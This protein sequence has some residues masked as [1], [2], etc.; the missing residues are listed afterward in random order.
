[1]DADALGRA[2][3]WLLR[4]THLMDPA[5]FAG[6]VDEAARQLGAGGAC[7]YL[8]SRDQQQLLPFPPG[9]GTAQSLDGTLAGRAYRT[10]ETV[11]PGDS[12]RAWVPLLD[13]TERLGVLELTA[14]PDSPVDNLVEEAVPFAALVAE[15]VVSKGQYSDAFERARR[16]VPMGIAAEMLWRQLPPLTYATPDVVVSA[17]LEPWNEVGG[18]AFD[19]SLDGDVLRLAVFDGMGHG[20]S[21]TLMAGVALAGYR[22]ARRSG[23]SLLETVAT[24][25]D[26]LG[27]Q[28]GPE[29]F[30]TALLAELQLKTGL[31]RMVSAA[32]PAPVLVRNGKAVGELGLTPGVPLG[33]GDRSDTVTELS[34]QPTDRLLLMTD[35]V[36]EA[37]SSDG[38]FFGIDRLLDLLVRQESLRQPPPET[39]RRLIAAVLEHQSGM[40]QDDATLLLLEWRGNTTAVEPY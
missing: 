9:A 33:L 6:D 11:V 35:G 28:F 29:G 17:Q 10:T 4:R 15:L 12:S 19:Y 32:H 2:L 40:L 26:V 25:D 39:L 37:R 36:V 31:V 23:Q 18:D 8:V 21:A 5:D 20:L 14:S 22:N 24:L 3:V 13:G 7:I 38:E 16:G 34:L 27:R 30:V 1:M